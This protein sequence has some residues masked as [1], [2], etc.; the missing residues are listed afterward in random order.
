MN[1]SN[2]P[3]TNS[4]VVERECIGELYDDE[5]YPQYEESYQYDNKLP[6]KFIAY[7]KYHPLGEQL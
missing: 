4:M 6:E 2:D 5:D 1:Y 7:Y 3:H